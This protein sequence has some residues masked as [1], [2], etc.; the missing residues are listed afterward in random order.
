[1][2]ALLSALRRTVSLV[3]RQIRAP[4]PPVQQS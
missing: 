1:M 3:H 4:Q 2:F